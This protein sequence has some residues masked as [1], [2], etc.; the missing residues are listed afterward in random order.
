MARFFAPEFRVQINGR[1]LPA[2]VS[3]TITGLSVQTALTFDSFSLTV[4]NPYPE[5]PWTHGKDRDLFAEGSGIVI[6][7]GYVDDL[8]LMIDGDITGMSPSFPASGNPTLR[9]RGQSRLYRLQFTQD[10]RTFQDVTDTDVARAI[11]QD[12]DFQ[13]RGDSTEV[14]YPL[15]SSDLKSD[16]EF[17]Q[18]RARQVRF[19]AYAEG[20]TLFFTRPRDTQAKSF[21]LVW[22][23]TEKNLKPTLDAIPLIQF[24][25]DMDVQGQ[26]TDVVVR[27]QH[28]TT[29]EIIEGRAGAGDEDSRMGG[30]ETGPQVAARAVG[31]SHEL[32]VVG[33]PVTSQQEA[34]QRAR[35]LYNER[36]STFVTGRG[37]TIGLPGLRAGRVI[38]LHGLGP[39][40]SGEYYVTAATHRMGSNGYQTDF[41]VRRNS[42]G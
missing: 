33:E 24:Q 19:E 12:H 39:R 32:T 23:R 13:F 11:A 34:D 30:R 10:E 18:Q 40:F 36:A 26:V 25:P 7:M 15:L 42:L 38:E 37:S 31:R 27:G 5:L 35:A 28:P 16:L 8:H 2:D 3:K 20:S 21:T 22:G 1:G 14:R 9:V 29:R 17:L 41:E 6:Q 4:A